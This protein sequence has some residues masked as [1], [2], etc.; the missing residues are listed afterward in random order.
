PTQEGSASAAAE[1]LPC[2]APS[3]APGVADGEIVVG[4]AQSL[5]G[6]VPGLGASNLAAIQAHVAYRNANGGVCGRQV[7]LRSADDGGDNA[8]NRAIIS[9]LGPQVAAFIAGTAGG[10]DGGAGAVAEQQLPVVGAS[11]SPGLEEVPTYYGVNPPLPSYDAVVGKYRF[12]HEQGVRKAAVVWISAAASPQQAKREMQL[13]RAAGIQVVSEQALP[14]STLS[15]D[16]AARQIA[17]SGADYMLFLHAD[18]PSASM[19]Q[20]I[21]DTGYQGLKFEEYIIAY[22]SKFPDLAGTAAEGAS[23]WLYALP[24][25]DGGAV[26][27]QAAYLEWMAQTAP[28]AALDSLAAQGWASAKLLFDSLEALPGPIARD[29]LL[30]QLAATGTYDAGG[31]L[32]PIDIGAQQS[33]NCVIGMIYEGGG[34]RRLAPPEGFLC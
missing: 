26:P 17:N 28:D 33:Q 11:I 14:L 8:R 3:D 24:A 5:S 19:A 18:G 22:G 10:A 34:W 25:E 30:A 16:S 7:V 1:A 29:A 2:S 4:T 12:L 15:Y 6:P 23:S 13:M 21:A 32:G 20:A 27:E 31:L 9:E